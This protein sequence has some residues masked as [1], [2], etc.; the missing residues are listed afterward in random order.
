LDRL[1]ALVALRFRLDLRLI[2]GSKVRLAGL[3]IALPGLALVST[4]QSVV[5]FFGI[6]FLE[7]RAPEALLPALS[8]LATL[9]G[10]VFLLSPL[11]AGVAFAES[12]DLHRLLHF[13]VP[14]TVLVVSS[15]GSNLLQPTVLGQVPVALALALA[16]GRGLSGA[17]VCLPLVALTFLFVLA[18]AQVVGLLLHGLSRNRRLHDRLLFV[19]IGVGFALSLVPIVLLSG[20]G[21]AF[22]FVSW[23]VERD[24]FAWSPFGWGLR[25]AAHAGRGEPGAAGALAALAGLGLLGAVALSAALVGRIYRGE[26]DLG[27]GPG[28]RDEGPSPMPLPGPTGA[29]LEKDF[30]T[31]WRDPRMKAMLFTGVAGPLILLLFWRGAG[32]AI[33]PRALMLLAS[34]IGLSTLG[35]NSFALEGRGLGLLFAF[36]IPRHRLL[37]AKNLG[38]IAMRL[39]GA[40]F[41]AIAVL[42]VGG[43]VLVP[44]VL[45]VMLVSMLVAC[46]AD[47]Y[48]SILH[49]V[50][51]PLPGRNPYGPASG[52]RGLGAAVVA[53]LLMVG[54]LALA[55][56]F[57]FLAWLPLLLDRPAFWLVSLPLALAGAGAVYVLLVLGAER[58]LLRR[59]PELLARMLAEE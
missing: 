59:E 51:M 44:A 55:A 20:G 48:M 41:M 4:L 42:V 39:P 47:N 52:G 29:L 33:S 13:P 12:H 17:L 40:V 49:P 34:A 37:M 23:V 7:A 30:R 32:G 31:T 25:A 3:L 53:A 26:L 15:L 50:P 38:A 18:A 24:L 56:P 5:A 35:S 6:R 57:A 43:P 1:I 16:L 11:L 45:T 19:G 27:G 21:R 22:A 8:V 58:L 36:P 14:K 54:A 28:R 9:A 2:F 10:M 46:A